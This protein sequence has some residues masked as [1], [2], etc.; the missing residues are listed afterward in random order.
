MEY[1]QHTDMRHPALGHSHAAR[2]HFV[3]ADRLQRLSGAGGPPTRDDWLSRR[4]DASDTRATPSG[5]TPDLASPEA[6]HIRPGSNRER[7]DARS[8]LALEAGEPSGI[9][10]TMSDISYASANPADAA[11]ASAPATA[12]ARARAERRRSAL[13]LYPHELRA[14]GLRPQAR[15]RHRRQG[16]PDEE[17]QRLHDGVQFPRGSRL[18]LSAIAAPPG[19]AFCDGSLERN[20]PSLRSLRC[21]SAPTT[22]LSF[23]SGIESVTCVSTPWLH[24]GSQR[25]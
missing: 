25:R 22:Y 1:R 3:A 6:P 13:D 8:R 24:P 14:A 23:V 11:P 18:R 16:Y 21:K 12:G 4:C 9:S 10:A 15:R 2:A 19:G 5:E 7:M 17:V 20:C